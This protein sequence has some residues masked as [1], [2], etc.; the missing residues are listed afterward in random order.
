MR[1][2]LL[3]WLALALL[4]R[5][6]RA[7]TPFDSV[8][9]T[10]MRDGV[11]LRGTVLF[12]G[13]GGRYPTLVYRTPYGKDA[14]IETYP[15]FRKAVARGYAVLAQ[16][17]RGRYTSDGTYVPY[18]QEPADGFDTIEWAAA[19]PWST[20]E[21]G[22]FGL[23]YPGAVQW[24]AATKG[25]P[26]LLAMVPAMTF[27]SPT[28]FWYAGG[29]FDLSW[30]TWIW[31]NIAPDLRVRN[32]LPGPRTYREAA[33]A[34]PGVR[35]RILDHVPLEDA[36]ELKEVAPWYVEWMRH[37]PNDR[38][39]DWAELRNKYAK[40]GAA[41]LNVSGWHDDPYGPEGAVTNF[42]GLL[43]SRRGAEPKTR[44]I[45]GPWVHGV[46]G[47]MA[48][49]TAKSGERVFGEAAGIDYDE[50][51][52]RFMDRYVRHLDVGKDDPLVRVFVMGENVW[53]SSDR[54]P[55]A[56][57]VP[58]PFYLTWTTGSRG[59]LTQDQLTGRATTRFV[60][61][62]SSPVTDPYAE[63]SGAH[64]YRALADQPNVATFETDPLQTD[65]RV[66]GNITARIFVSTLVPDTDLWVRLFDV[67]PDGTA[68]NLMSPGLD[69]LRAS[70]R[71][72]GPER[73]L[74]EPDKVYE[75][76]L[77]NLLTGN[78]FQRGHR[79]RI[80]LT[81]AF[82][83]HFSRNLH[84]GALETESAD[85]RSAAITIHHDRRYPSQIIVPVVP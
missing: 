71:E 36:P 11:T 21:I 60:S 34:W 63:Q 74:L 22:T 25:P 83:P 27:S 66:V 14:A 6:A 65:L 12:P 80:V 58:T 7:Q 45:L 28:N 76:V 68:W 62:P 78:L 10:P 18:N 57:T 69:V 41:V 59:R 13:R 30:P 52:L 8:V 64:D 2:A 61:D 23:S 20:G 19:Q 15:M 37:P 50:E 35:S 1:R 42:R 4:V 5:G 32:N 85:M 33:A 53:R 75:L 73:K 38:W 51:I 9:S 79:I 67:A 44:L 17:V 81:T 82:M 43:A 54:W 3:S 72:G 70:Y 77:P 40:V 39:W 31:H 56:G 47:M 29:I 24:L 48:S 55:L 46:G 26:H 49:P 84:T 16:D